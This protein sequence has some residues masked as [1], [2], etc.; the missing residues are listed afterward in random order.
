MIQK[1]TPTERHAPIV[2]LETARDRRAA[3]AREYLVDLNATKAAI[4]AGYSPKTAGAQGH[5]L[6]KNVEIQTL[7]QKGREAAAARTE[8]T[9]D[10]VLKEYA[11]IAFSGLSRFV[12][13]DAD[14]VPRIDLSG[15]SAEDL[16]LLAEV[17]IDTQHAKG[18]PLVLKIRI[19]ALDK[20]NAL[21]KLA[22][23]LGLFEARDEKAAEDPLQQMIMAAQGTTLQVAALREMK[24]V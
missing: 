12:Q 18:N 13:I 9:V 21:E 11:R 7:I 23:H 15:C 17:Q 5:R 6:L 20:L 3:F 19:K 14:G 8:I 4:R 1:G 22:R 2:R 16:D 10:R 24:P